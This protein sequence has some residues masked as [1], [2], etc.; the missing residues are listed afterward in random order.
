MLT[1]PRRT[2]LDNHLCQRK[3]TASGFSSSIIDWIGSGQ[4]F[5]DSQVSAGPGRQ[6]VVDVVS[7]YQRSVEGHWAIEEIFSAGTTVAVLH[8]VAALSLSVMRGRAGS[9]TLRYLL[10][11][12]GRLPCS[13]YGGKPGA[14]VVPSGC[15]LVASS[16]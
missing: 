4:V 1:Y 15:G 6:G 14:V 12:S 13:G 11:W 10:R 5:Q 2:R 3:Y 7:V 16:P 8:C 9:A